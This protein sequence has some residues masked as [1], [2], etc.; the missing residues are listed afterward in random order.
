L[1]RFNSCK[2]KHGWFASI[3]FLKK[4]CGESLDK[5]KCECYDFVGMIFEKNF[6]ISKTEDQNNKEKA[7]R[8]QK[9]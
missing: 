6:L 4:G 9:C 1:F 8:Y 5:S 2:T 3:A 7:R